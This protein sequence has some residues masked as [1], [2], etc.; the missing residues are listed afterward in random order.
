MSVSTFSVVHS[1]IE[2]S[3]RADRID[4]KAI[5]VAA[6]SSKKRRPIVSIYEATAK[7]SEIRLGH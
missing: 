3:R 6:I 2:A 5:I 1:Y 7:Y 4:G